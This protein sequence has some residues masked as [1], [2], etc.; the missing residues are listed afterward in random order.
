[1]EIITAEA[2]H[3]DELR[4]FVGIRD[5]KTIDGQDEISPGRN[6]SRVNTVN[7][8]AASNE[9][10]EIQRSQH[11]PKPS[12]DQSKPKTS[13]QDT[14]KFVSVS[15]SEIPVTQPCKTVIIERSPNTDS[16]QR[17]LVEVKST[18][19]PKEKQLFYQDSQTMTKEGTRPSEGGNKE[20]F[21]SIPTPPSYQEALKRRSI[22]SSENTSN[23]GSSFSSQ[24]QTFQP[25]LKDGEW[26]K[27]M[28]VLRTMSTSSRF[29]LDSLM[30][31][32]DAMPFS[33]DAFGRLSMSERKGRAHLDATKSDFYS[34]LKKSK[35]L[36]NVHSSKLY[37]ISF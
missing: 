25:D 35:S 12:S 16:R 28:D 11:R 32:P 17:L 7:I 31:S 33:R 8:K 24:Q 37:D 36:E 1:M 29:S 19:Y 23:R 6:S 10:T 18:V 4:C 27:D 14:V 30:M 26:R 34:R 22:S 20:S 9:E 15:S 3:H 5:S 13:S 21:E 2:T